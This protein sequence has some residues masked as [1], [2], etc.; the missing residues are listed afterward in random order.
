MAFTGRVNYADRSV[1]AQD[2]ARREMLLKQQAQQYEMDNRRRQDMIAMY[3]A[4]NGVFPRL[5][6]LENEFSYLATKS[7]E[8]YHNKMA[9][10]MAKGDL[11]YT[12][13]YESNKAKEQARAE[14]QVYND[15]QKK[16]KSDIGTVMAN[17]GQISI[18]PSLS[19][20]PDRNPYIYKPQTEEGFMAYKGA[21]FVI[22]PMSLAALRKDYHT[23]KLGMDAAQA[24]ASING[25]VI[26]TTTDFVNY[27]NDPELK[28]TPELK[29]RQTSYIQY[30]I[31]NTTKSFKNTEGEEVLYGSQFTALLTD[32]FKELDDDRKVKY[33]MAALDGMVEGE[34]AIRA[35][36]ATV[37]SAF[38]SG[39]MNDGTISQDEKDKMQ[40]AFE[41]ATRKADGTKVAHAISPLD[42]PE[43]IQNTLKQ[44]AIDEP[45]I[46]EQMFGKRETVV[47]ERVVTSGSR[48][49]DEAF[50]GLGTQ[51]YTTSMGD[52]I[53]LGN[54][55]NI[56]DEKITAP[57]VSVNKVYN[58]TTGE[59]LNNIKLPEDVYMSGVIYGRDKKAKYM[60]FETD[61]Y[62]AKQYEDG[63]TL[64]RAGNDDIAIPTT[65]GQPKT[66]KEIREYIKNL[67]RG[68]K[69]LIPN[70]D[71]NL[72]QWNKGKLYKD[73]IK[74][75]SDEE[76]IE[77]LQLEPYKKPTTSTYLTPVQGNFPSA[78]LG[79]WEYSSDAERVV[80][81]HNTKQLNKLFAE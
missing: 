37:K 2:S 28:G 68:A 38:A 72:T 35:A 7:V 69:K 46:S 6:E 45:T 71:P 42:F 79:K 63:E 80:D 78:K 33:V 31:D 39:M 52:E 54:Y 65:G 36:Q 40:T 27:Y 67:D 32:G 12:D 74:D 22:N 44:Y 62:D 47:K 57:R 19:D 34:D 61:K 58:L 11:K 21:G 43:L 50:G 64:Y 73:K 59:M 77:Y 66:I 76:L 3:M 55:Q 51:N 48:K 4:K 23:S 16:L 1:L 75:M 25:N 41:S 26:T 10:Q 18:D 8:E 14:I 60:V 5:N 29:R 81:E 15:S 17:A 30:V 24:D 20:T 49:G 13:L 9:Q 53:S 56:L 70:V